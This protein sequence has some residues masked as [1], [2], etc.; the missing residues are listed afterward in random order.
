MSRAAWGVLWIVG[1]LGVFALRL[2]P[3][4][5]QR[6]WIGVVLTV[7]TELTVL[8]RTY[9]QVSHRCACSFLRAPRRPPSPR[10]HGRRFRALAD[11]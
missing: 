3:D 2:L 1:L 9:P 10:T 4:L 8:R 11:R 5:G 6:D 7:L